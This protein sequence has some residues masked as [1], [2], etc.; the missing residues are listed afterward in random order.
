MADIKCRICGEPWDSYGIYHGDMTVR[1]KD[2]FL[3]GKGCP[4]CKGV[5]PEGKDK[6]DLT[7]EFLESLAD[8]TDKDP[9]ELLGEVENLD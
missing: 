1:E 9:I 4:C 3:K 2:V 8:S 6:D 5:K 7:L